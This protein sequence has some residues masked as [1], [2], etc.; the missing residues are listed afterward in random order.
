MVSLRIDQGRPPVWTRR[1][2]NVIGDNRMAPAPSDHF[3]RSEWMLALVSIAVVV[4]VLY[5]AKGVLVPLMLALLLSF[6]LA[7]VCDLL[8]RWKLGRIPAV[9]VTAVLAFTVLGM[10]AWT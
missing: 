3:A 10:V 1:L 8:E 2:V 7:P 6:L 4:A 9:L 5:L